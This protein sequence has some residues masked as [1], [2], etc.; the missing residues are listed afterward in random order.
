MIFSPTLSCANALSMRKKKLCKLK[1]PKLIGKQ[2]RMWL[3]KKSKRSKR[4]KKPAKP[5]LLKRKKN[6]IL[7]SISSRTLISVLIPWK[8]LMT[9]KPTKW[10]SNTKFPRKSLKPFLRKP[11]LSHYNITLVLNNLAKMTAKWVAVTK[12][13]MYPKEKKV[14]VKIKNETNDWKNLFVYFKYH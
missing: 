11:S 4:T 7:S 8:N 9:K 3:S 12:R 14:V 1:E 6:N 13:M 2:A 5:E 10:M